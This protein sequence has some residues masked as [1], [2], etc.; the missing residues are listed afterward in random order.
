[1]PKG[2][3]ILVVSIDSTAGWTAA[4]RDL[5]GSLEAAGAEVSSVGTGPVPHMRTFALTDLSQ[6][7]LARRVTRRALALQRPD[8]IVYCSIVASLLW[9]QP[10][11]IWLDSIAAENRPGRH[12]VWQRT[13]ERRRLHEAPMV[14]TMSPRSLQPLRGPI[15]TSVV[16]PSPVDTSGATDGTRDIDVLTYAGNPAKKRLDY[17]LDTWERVRRPGEKLWVAGIDGFEPREGVESAGRLAPA[18][19]RALLRRVR[20]F[21]AAPTREDYGIA[22]LEAL[23]DGCLLVTTPAPGPYP[24]LDLAR[25]LDPRL[26][27]EDI[28]PA[29]RIALDDP[30]ARYADRAREL[31]RP[32]GR[33]AVAETLAERVIPALLPGFGAG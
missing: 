4:A 20:V 14:L 31:L 26:V 6:A 19:Y 28:A 32:F 29:L 27:A 13:V 21:L 8:A 2:P 9:P 1:V 12:G 25:E 3:R 23:A 10:G 7:W 33:A 30:A 17:V 24:A 22:P 16:V 15:P 18:D 11:A 5:A